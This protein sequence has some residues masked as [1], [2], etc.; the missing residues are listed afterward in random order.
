M[1]IRTAPNPATA[2][3]WGRALLGAVVLGPLVA[4]VLLPTGLGL[5]RYVVT[6]GESGISRGT[7]LFERVVPVSDLRAGD[8][9]TYE[10]PRSADAGGTV[11]ERIVSVGPAGIVTRGSTGP[12]AD[13]W[14]SRADRSTVRVVELEVPVVGWAYLL[15]TSPQGWALALASAV[16]L[17]LLSRRRDHRVPEMLDRAPELALAGCRPGDDGSTARRERGHR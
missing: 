16:A 12:V 6:G 11:T 10:R 17:V 2:T 13:R 4:L 9:I 14:V 8:V 15:L 3:P 1:E 7:L 5:D